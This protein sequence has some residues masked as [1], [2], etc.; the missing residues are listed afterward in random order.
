MGKQ[1]VSALAC[2]CVAMPE[3]PI[4]QVKS[5]RPLGEAQGF[6]VVGIHNGHATIAN[7][8]L[9]GAPLAVLRAITAIVIDALKCRAI[10]RPPHIGQEVFKHFPSIAHADATR[11]VVFKRD[12]V[13]VLAPLPH[14]CPDVI[15]AA[16]SSAMSESRRVVNDVAAAGFLPGVGNVVPKRLD[17]IAAVTSKKPPSLPVSREVLHP[18]YCSEPVEFLAS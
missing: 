2:N 4:R 14:A 11:A 18:A 10:R 1:L 17:F 5:F 8:L 13:F 12:S 7:L 9:S 15:S 6:V 16:T 3:R